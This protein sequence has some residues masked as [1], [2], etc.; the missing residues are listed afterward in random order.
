MNSRKRRR[1]SDVGQIKLPKSLEHHEAAGIQP[2]YRGHVWE[3]LDLL[4]TNMRMEGVCNVGGEEDTSRLVIRRRI[5]RDSGSGQVFEMVFRDSLAPPFALKVM[6]H[7]RFATKARNKVEI[8]HANRASNL[9]VEYYKSDGARGSPYFPMVFSTGSCP[10]ITLDFPRA[11]S[12]KGIDLYHRAT[13]Y[14]SARDLVRRYVSADG[15]ARYL[16]P[17]NL[18]L[19]YMQNEAI[20][21]FA[22]YQRLKRDWTEGGDIEK[23]ILADDLTIALEVP[24]EGEYMATELAWG[25]L[26]AFLRNG[27][28][29]YRTVEM[30]DKFFGKLLQAICD[31]QTLL[32]LLHTDLHWGNVLV[33]L[34]KD[35]DALPLIHDFDGAT[36]FEKTE[37]FDDMTALFK[38]LLNSETETGIPFAKRFI[39]KRVIAKMKQLLY[40]HENDSFA[41]MSDV[42]RWWET[43]QTNWFGFSFG[44][45]ISGE[46][47]NMEE[48]PSRIDEEPFDL[49]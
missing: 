39:P 28:E 40:L 25:D 37:Q 18:E 2:I 36:K 30:L 8:Y 21:P 44:G 32:E 26:E 23:S 47:E 16:D 11:D 45:G 17:A 34:V 27:P 1:E 29:E 49:L 24:I 19:A 7:T 3:S 43:T 15:W 46:Y 22:L 5:G 42:V 14:N 4:F 9:V 20:Q 10:E 38:D 31:L 6:P 13:I 12:E 35:G 48:I 33:Q 41:V